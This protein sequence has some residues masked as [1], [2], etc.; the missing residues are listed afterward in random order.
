MKKTLFIFLFISSFLF[1]M[2][3]A[4]LNSA[5]KTELVEITGIGSVKAEAIIQ[6][7]EVNGGFTSF[8]D[9][10]RVKGIG[11]TLSQRVKNFTHLEDEKK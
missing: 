11:K 1:S 6:E 3:L 4:E 10:E 2:T 9:L 7:R 8:E 5:S